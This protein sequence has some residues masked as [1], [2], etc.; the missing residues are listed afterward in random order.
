MSNRARVP[1]RVARRLGR[2][3]SV[4]V[5]VAPFWLK[6]PLYRWTPGGFGHYRVLRRYSDPTYDDLRDRHPVRRRHFGS[7]G[8]RPPDDCGL[9]IRDYEDYDEYVVHQRQKLDAKIKS[10][11][12]FPNAVVSEVR[13]RFYRRF[14]HLIGLLPRDAT[15]VCLG[16][17][18]GTEVE[19]LHDLGFRNAYGIDLNPGPE[20]PLVRTGDFQNLENE[21][22][23][24]DLVYSN[25]LDHTFDL[26]SFYQESARV[27]KPN[28]LALYDF[29]APYRP[30]EKA[31]FEA[32]LWLR[33]EDVLLRALTHFD[34]VLKLETEPGWTWVLLSGP[35]R[36]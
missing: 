5:R 36:A 23:S 26:D 35:R 27:L 3:A 20:N 16:A 8:L 29:G 6:S 34:R 7:S 32:T 28:G 18:Q 15:I 30:G 33:V 9:V 1:G 17:R 31:P 10:G 11:D 4:A 22:S 13:R 19:V 14:R 12:G 21:T 24:V 2:T 25:S